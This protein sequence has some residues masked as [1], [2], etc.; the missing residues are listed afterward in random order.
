MK[1]EKE[2]VTAILFPLPLF[3]TVTAFIAVPM[4]GTVYGSFFRDVTFLQ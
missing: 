4:A 3:I 2:P 1:S